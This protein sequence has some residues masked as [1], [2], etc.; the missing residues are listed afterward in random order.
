MQYQT[1][2][3]DFEARFRLAFEIVKK[4]VPKGI[5]FYIYFTAELSRFSR[6]N[7]G[8]IRQSGLVTDQSLQIVI[9]DGQRSIITTVTLPRGENDLFEI[10]SSLVASTCADLPSIPIDPFIVSPSGTQETRELISG[11][12]PTSELEQAQLCEKLAKLPL[13]GQFIGGLIVRAAATSTGAFHWFES[14][15]F[16]FRYTLSHT[17]DKLTQSTYAGAHWEWDQL[18]NLLA[19]SEESLRLL[20]STKRRLKAGNYR[21]YLCPSA[22]ASLVGMLGH[23]ALSESSIRR[24]E[25]MFPAEVDKRIQLSQ[26]LSI[27]QDF[28]GTHSPRFNHYGELAPSNLVVIND[29]HL[30]NTLISTRTGLEYRI[31]PNGATDSESLANI[32]VKPGSLKEDEILKSLDTGIYITNL[33]YLN[34]SNRNASRITGM[35]RFG[36]LWADKGEFVGPIE[37]LRFDDSL[38]LLLGHKLIEL[39]T[40]RDTFLNMATYDGRSTGGAITPGLLIDDVRFPL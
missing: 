8:R 35:T 21:C 7:L 5:D 1:D 37:D 34:W 38:N 20:G 22:S 17:T 15:S 29:G 31:E 18:D 16:A 13:T 25:S 11:S 6:F 39:T 24:G 2:S 23:G 33:H 36:A 19:K 32:N 10:L 30:E 3:N 9:T 14:D 12:A 4:L 27:I 26:K 28:S 40:F